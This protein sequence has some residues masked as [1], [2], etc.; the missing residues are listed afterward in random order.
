ML[1]E[2]IC[3][4]ASQTM[5]RA[6][7]FRRG[8]A[9][10]TSVDHRRHLDEVQLVSAGL[11]YDPAR[12]V[13]TGSGSVELPATTYEELVERLLDGPLTVGELRRF[14]AL[15][16]HNDHEVRAVVT[17]LAAAGYGFPTL[18]D[19]LRN[20][21]LESTWRMNRALVDASRRGDDRG[22]LV[23]PATGGGIGVSTLVA[24]VIGEHWDGVPLEAQPLSDAVQTRAQVITSAQG[25]DRDAGRDAVDSAVRHAIHLLGG[26]FGSLGIRAPTPPGGAEPAVD[27]AVASVAVMDG[28]ASVVA[29]R[30]PN[31]AWISIGAEIVALDPAGGAHVITETGALLWPLLDGATADAELAADVAAVFGI[32][33][34]AA[35]D[36]VRRLLGE[37]IVA[38]LAVDAD[39]RPTTT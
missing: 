31:V 10:V 20:G 16:E 28:D 5:F 35:L 34:D 24:L 27:G 22:I 9:L 3:D 30:A 12:T 18:P 14:S 33:V 23:S 8:L 32:D 29:Q 37:M 2:T 6:D 4:L 17:M 38:G 19:W 39:E 36:D 15:S 21:S 1:R 11:A 26:H 13:P 25:S 7:V